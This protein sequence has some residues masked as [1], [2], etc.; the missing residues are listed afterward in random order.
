MLIYIYIFLFFLVVNTTSN[1]QDLEQ[2]PEE[3]PVQVSGSLSLR[4]TAFSSSREI[5]Y[6]DPFMW[7]L[8]GS[9][10]L[11]LYGITFPFSFSVSNK[12]T[13]FR[14][15]FNQFGMSPYY[16]WL[17]LHLGYR[18][19]SF[20]NYTLGGHTILGAGFEAEPSIFRFGFMYGRLRK[21]NE[22]SLNEAGNFLAPYKRTGFAA[23]IGIGNNSNYID[24][25]LFKAKDDSTSVNLENTGLGLQPAENMV[26]GLKARQTLFNTFLLN[27]DF[28]FS[29]YTR[30]L[31]SD[32]LNTEK[33]NIP[34]IFSGLYDVRESTSFNL[35]GT[36]SLSFRIKSIRFR[37]KYLRIEPDY[38]SMGTYFI[39]NDRENITVSPSFSILKSKIR[40]RGSVGFQ[41]NNL[42]KDKINQ[43]KRWISSINLNFIPSSKV[44][45]NT[46]YSN[47]Q[48]NQT[49]IIHPFDTTERRDRIDKLLD[50][51]KLKQFSHNLNANINISLGSKDH[52][53]NIN[54]NINYQIFDSQTEAYTRDMYSQNI[55]P[56]LGY[57]YRNNVINYGLRLNLNGNSF[58]TADNNSFRYGITIGGNKSFLD[59]DLRTSLSITRY[60]NFQD[61]LK[62]S[63]TVSL[64]GQANYQLADQHRLSF[65]L[66]YMSRNAKRELE[67]SYNEFLTTIGY[68]YSLK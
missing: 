12:N 62:T 21:A 6:R 68:S 24:L 28:G 60:S 59:K 41:R 25:I 30:N 35:A 37:L 38:R 61:Q 4:M 45:I 3:E 2:I 52:R 66:N 47:Y 5:S 32:T 8:S 55:S 7:T 46:N 9:P 14:Q 13:D 31:S 33:Y 23:K 16:K 19:I 54:T 20:S 50:S 11:S 48:I 40:V 10:T 58:K 64:R 42:F 44:N 53:H 1:A 27:V 22:L 36:G 17:T 56:N 26:L 34:G 51:L 57:N 43:T 49:Q 29:T 15:P 63:E 18:N 67:T 39:N 65:N